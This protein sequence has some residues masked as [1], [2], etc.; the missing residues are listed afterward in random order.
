MVGSRCCILVF[1]PRTRHLA[2][3]PMF[4]R[5]K[6]KAATANVPAEWREDLQLG[7]SVDGQELIVDGLRENV[8]ELVLDQHGNHVM[9]KCRGDSYS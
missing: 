3:A 9:Q 6:S 1:R 7:E 5:S 4:M 2:L 8:T